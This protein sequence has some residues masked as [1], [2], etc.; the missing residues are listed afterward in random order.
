MEDGMV[1]SFYG[2]ADERRNIFQNFKSLKVSLN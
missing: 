2:S 1:I